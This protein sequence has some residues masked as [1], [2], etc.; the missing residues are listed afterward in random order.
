MPV[1]RPH[2][3]FASGTLFDEH[4]RSTL[5]GPRIPAV[6]AVLTGHAVPP[7]PATTGGPATGLTL[8]RRIDAQVEG[9][10]LHLTDDD[11]TTADAHEAGHGA[12]RRRVVLGSGEWAW[13][14]LDA[15]PLRP[16]ARIVLAGDSIAYGRCDPRGGWAGHLAAAHIAANETAHRFFNLAVPG[17]TLADVAAQTPALLPARLPDTLLVAAGINDAAAGD[18]DLAR[19]AE[20]LDSLAADA[21]AAGARL[22]VVGPTWLDEEHAPVHE[23]LRFTLDR[24]LALR[25]ALRAWCETRHVDHLDPWEPLRDRPDLLADGLHPTAEGHEEVHRFLARLAGVR[26]VAPF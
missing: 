2:R 15:R 6:P 12:V 26:A 9:T 20:H 13:A 22:V 4:V 17:A 1:P 25:S 7:R 10:V 19:L 21:L 14:Y 16:A 5:F 8:E 24:A 11:L 18:G 3:L 23:G